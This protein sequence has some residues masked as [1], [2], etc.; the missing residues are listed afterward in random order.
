[1]EGRTPH[2]T[3]ENPLNFPKTLSLP[4][5]QSDLITASKMSV[6]RPLIHSLDISKAFNSLSSKEK[7]YAHYMARYVI[8]GKQ[9]S[10]AALI[11]RQISERHGMEPGSSFARYRRNQSISST[12]FSSFTGVAR[13][14]GT[15]LLL[16]NTSVKK[17]AIRFWIMQQHFFLT[18]GITMF[19]TLYFDSLTSKISRRAPATRN[20]CHQFLLPHWKSCQRSPSS[21]SIFMRR[22]LTR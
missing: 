13:G 3:L 19:V 7:H 1:M 20:S 9:E 22:S 12:S 2:A 10:G 18:S 14:I 16:R 15:C 4:D 8:E 6:P 11:L 5:I 21:L 17:T